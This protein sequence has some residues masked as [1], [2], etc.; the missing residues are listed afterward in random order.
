MTTSGGPFW[1]CDHLVFL[2]VIEQAVF[3]SGLPYGSVVGCQPMVKNREVGQNDGSETISEGRKGASEGSDRGLDGAS[4]AAP[5]GRDRVIIEY[6]EA[7]LA[8]AREG[9][10][11]FAVASVGM[12]V[13]ASV[14]GPDGRREPDRF[15]VA[16]GAFAGS[17]AGMLH[18]A[19]R[20]GAIDDVSRGA[21]LAAL[22]LRES[23]PA[24]SEDPS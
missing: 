22:E 14:L 19:S 16:V 18:P 1:V 5:E 3:R 7:C 2:N 10:V 12:A 8:A 21:A 11:V 23:A 20:E 4:S 6:L 15:S 17:L 24:S 9:R 13:P